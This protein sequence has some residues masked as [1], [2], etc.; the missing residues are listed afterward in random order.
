MQAVKGRDTTPER[1]VRS[2]LHRLG[3]RFALHRED[4]PGKPDIVMPAR[5]SIVLV[6]GCFWHGHTCTRGRRKPTAN[7]RYWSTKIGRY[8]ARDRRTVAA[9]HRAAWRVVVVWECQTHDR[10][11]LT[12]R[13]ARF[14]STR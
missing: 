14:L 11:R 7:A 6:N 9:L 10:L 1:V 13:L 5:R 3:C 8:T 12:V 2:V 4:L